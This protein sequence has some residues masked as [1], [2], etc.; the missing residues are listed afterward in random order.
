MPTPLHCC[1]VCGTSN[2][3]VQA[4]RR[5]GY[6]GKWGLEL[7]IKE[8]LPLEPQT[9]L[10][11]IST[12]RVESYT[13]AGNHSSGPIWTLESAAGTASWALLC[14]CTVVGERWDASQPCS[15]HGSTG[16]RKSCWVKPTPCRANEK[17][18]CRS[19][20]FHSESVNQLE[21]MRHDCRN[22]EVASS[23]RALT[24]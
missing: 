4:K 13:Q 14:I 20:V 19:W 22:F 9:S 3:S 2:S 16:A 21:V 12:S 10:D 24:L 18:D 15:V 7:I 23:D 17:D 1:S 11:P 8:L 5:V 6:P